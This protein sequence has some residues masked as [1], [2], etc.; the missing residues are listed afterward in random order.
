MTR[1]FGIGPVAALALA[2][3]GCDATRQMAGALAELQNVQRQVAAATGH[4][5]VRVNLHNDIYLTVGLVN[6][7][8]RE[9]PDE[10]RKAKARDIARVAYRSL[11]SRA[12][13]R[14]VRVTFV[15][16]ATRFLVFSYTDATDVFALKPQELSGEEGAEGT[17][18]VDGGDRF[19][20]IG[21]G[22]VAI[23]DDTRHADAWYYWLG[24]GD[25]FDLKARRKVEP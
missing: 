3:P 22:R 18:V 23:Y 8:L 7:P 13:L 6:S 14:E 9:L 19:E 16:Q 4:D 21:T 15:V 25:R 17:L 10:D 1:R 20:V 24:P 2:L 11:E 5:N 12:S